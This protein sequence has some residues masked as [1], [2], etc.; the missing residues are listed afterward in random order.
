MYKELLDFYKKPSKEQGK[1]TLND[2][3]LFLDEFYDY[4]Y[5]LGKEG[6]KVKGIVDKKVEAMVLKN[7][8]RDN[9]ICLVNTEY[10]IYIQDNKFVYFDV[11]HNCWKQ[12]RD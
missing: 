3:D 1:L 4:I 6:V 11:R 8:T 2:G 9:F 12:I 5:T 7:N 10:L